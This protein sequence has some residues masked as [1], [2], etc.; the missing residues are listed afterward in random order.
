MPA[1]WLITGTSRG[2]GLELVRQLVAAGDTVLATCRNP[3]SADRLRAV[4][5]SGPGVLHIFPLDVLDLPNIAAASATAKQLLGDVPL[6]YLINNAGVGGADSAPQLDPSELERQFRTHVIGMNA[7]VRAFLPLL[8]GGK[9]IVV[10]FT[11]GLASIGLD[12]GPKNASYS[13]AKAALNMLTYKLAKSLT[14][15]TLFVVDPGWVKTDMGGEGAQ[16]D[17]DVAVKALIALF[18]RASLDLSG[19]FLRYDGSEL[20]W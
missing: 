5:R 2:I 7:V 13:I 1:T 14:D 12:C 3:D 11:S 18:Q 19:K 20:P 6:D 9:R 8:D 16:L 4:E 15:T 10:N 17:V